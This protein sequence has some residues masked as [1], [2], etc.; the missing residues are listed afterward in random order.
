MDGRGPANGVLDTP[1]ESEAAR[2]SLRHR[3]DSWNNFMEATT[4]TPDYVL[5]Q[6]A[7]KEAQRAKRRSSHS[8][9]DAVKKK[10]M[11]VV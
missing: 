3:R 8:K 7:Q 11:E 2:R 10:P 9:S 1:S 5:K 4:A 6:Q